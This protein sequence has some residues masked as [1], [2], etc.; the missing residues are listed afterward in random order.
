MPYH[1]TTMGVIPR[2]GKAHILVIIDNNN[3]T[4]YFKLVNS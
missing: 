3:I 2:N 1:A 4:F